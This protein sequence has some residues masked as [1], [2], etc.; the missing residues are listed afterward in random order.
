MCPD[1]AATITPPM[2]N[3]ERRKNTARRRHE[4]LSQ[5]VS[6]A[7]DGKL[8]ILL[9]SLRAAD[10]GELLEG[11]PAPERARVVELLDVRRAARTLKRARAPVAAEVLGLLERAQAADILEWMAVDDRASLLEHLEPSVQ[12]ELL[13]EM[14]QRAARE[15]RDSL[16]WPAHSAG[17]LIQ[18]S[19]ARVPPELTVAAA[20]EA[21]RG[22]PQP[23]RA[24]DIYAV[25]AGG[26]LHG[27]ISFR[28]LVYAPA[29][30][31]VRSLMNR[32][33]VTVRPG[34]DQERVAQLIAKYDLTALPVVDDRGRFLGV[35]TIDDVLDVLESE[36]GEDV[37][38]MGA[39][40]TSAIADQPYFALG[41]RQLVKSRAGWLML[42][43]VA[44]T[45]TGAVL[46]HFEDEL[47]RVVALSFFIPLL[48]GTGGNAGSQT[49]STVIR[50][51]SI[52]DIR[53]GDWLRVVRREASLGVM[54]G[55]ILGL[56][57][58]ARAVLWGM[59][60]QMGI[61][62][63]VSIL[64]ICIWSNTVGALVPMLAQRLKVDPTVVS[65]PLITTLVDGTGLWIYLK[66]AGA[67]LGL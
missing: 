50:G 48:I 4:E 17:R 9:E 56:T 6:T 14:E 39:V 59:S 30:D 32:D 52:G 60:A 64:A 36:H 40:E 1:M 62:V 3:L 23:E 33:T 46:R 49:V 35:I 42:L 20:L 47:A 28:D 8:I 24:S 53:T 29:A 44:E 41:L 34:E 51:L 45:A 31:T 26:V 19:V 55:L 7:S 27:V 16:A 21:I 63:G 5:Q 2:S 12:E 18:T 11:L 13:A 54:L 38:N 67:V 22:Q 61:A 57:A 65:A 37:L 66:V 58:F 43:F 25:D 15:A 10:V